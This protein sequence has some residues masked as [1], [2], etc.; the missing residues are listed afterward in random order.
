MQVSTICYE[1]ASPDKCRAIVNCNPSSR[2]FGFHPHSDNDTIDI[3]VSTG[4]GACCPST[5]A[6][7]GTTVY[8]G[9]A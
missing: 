2:V 4:R 9:E 7:T 1:G 6:G 5:E 3:D 8:P